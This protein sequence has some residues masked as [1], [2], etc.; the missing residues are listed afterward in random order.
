[1]AFGRMWNALQVLSLLDAWLC[2]V[3]LGVAFIFVELLHVC[4]V[5]MMLIRCGFAFA[6]IA[7]NAFIATAHSTPAVQ[8]QHGIDEQQ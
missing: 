8:T 1:M 6:W 4:L 7:F 3:M 2:G 5:P